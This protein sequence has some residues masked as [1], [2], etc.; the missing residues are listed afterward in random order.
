M[1][2]STESKLKKFQNEISVIPSPTSILFG[3]QM[4]AKL[5]SN[6]NFVILSH[7]KVMD[8]L[9]VLP[10]QL[11]TNKGI[12]GVTSINIKCTNP[13]YLSAC[14]KSKHTLH[15]VTSL[16][17]FNK[18]CN[19]ICIQCKKFHQRGQFLILLFQ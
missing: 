17:A 8:L 2:I 14:L 13:P 19:S 3:V 4:T 12:L 7:F 9:Y 18:K 10:P 5:S 16:K 11:Q 15:I 1:L 6:I